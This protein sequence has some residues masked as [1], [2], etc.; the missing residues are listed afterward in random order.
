MTEHLRIATEDGSDYYDLLHDP[1]RK[2]WSGY[3]ETVTPQGLMERRY[4]VVG[5]HLVD[6]GRLAVMEALKRI[7]EFGRRVNEWQLSP[8]AHPSIWLEESAEGEAPIKRALIQSIRVRTRDTSGMGP[9]LGA[10]TLFGEVSVFTTTHH[11]SKI[12]RSGSK[13]A[14][15]CLGGMV[16]I[17][18][19]GTLDARMERLALTAPAEDRIHNAWIG[20]RDVGAGVA[21][22]NPIICFYDI[23]NP[24]LPTGITAVSDSNAVLPFAIQIN[25]SAVANPTTLID[26]GYTTIFFNY[27]T[28]DFSHW[29][30]RY[31]AI[32]RYRVV[33]TA[34]I[35]GFQLSYGQPLAPLRP[36]NETVYLQGT[37]NQY[38]LIDVGEVV[39]PTVPISNLQLSQT[40]QTVYDTGFTYATEFISGAAATDHLVIDCI[41][42]IPAERM[43]TAER[44]PSLLFY[45]NTIN[46]IATEREA[47]VMG[48][49]NLV[50]DGS[51]NLSVPPGGGLAV[52]LVER[53]S[54]QTKTDTA[55]V[56]WSAFNRYGRY[57][58][59]G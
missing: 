44:V 47:A 10:G 50:V 1:V 39:I 49:R 15:S 57:S 35:I 6:G 20:I 43:A 55:T 58:G 46:W 53:Q 27:G 31:R 34:A 33:G 32:L 51:N 8:T 56:N 36:R 25:H 23:A 7:E 18:G 12:R 40:V 21:D 22:F 11:E 2:M 45:T 13:S 3:T 29:K 28:V 48:L 17:A 41:I 5:S 54:A 52:I 9:M 4:S 24:P 26:R 16:E 30:G 14:V 38:K 37:N 42:L 19:G 59:N